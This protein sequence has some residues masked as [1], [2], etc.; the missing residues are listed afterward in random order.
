MYQGFEN[1]EN[2]PTFSAWAAEEQGLARRDLRESPLETLVHYFRD[3]PPNYRESKGFRS[4]PVLSALVLSLSYYPIR[5][6]LGHWMLYTHLMSRFVK[7][8]EFPLSGLQAQSS[9]LDIHD[10]QC[11]RRRSK[12]CLRKLDLLSDFIDNWAPRNEEAS[13]FWQP[14][15]R[16][17]DFI[18]AEITK[19]N[20]SLEGAVPLATSVVQ[21]HESRQ[22]IA[23]AVNVRRLTYI[24]LIFA[25]MSWVASIFSMQERFVPGNVGCW[26]YFAT[27]LPLMGLVLALSILNVDVN[28]VFVYLKNTKKKVFI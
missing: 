6:A 20:H 10:L 25:P 4:E 11:W 14:V 27:A 22:S 16:D 1:F 18:S 24:A 17:I 2:L 28:T 8:Y 9:G 23:E 19:Y 21:L 3:L 26:I 5:I 12:Q 15:H 7:H 13:N